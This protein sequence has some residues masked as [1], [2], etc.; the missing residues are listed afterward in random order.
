M[1]RWTLL[2]AALLLATVTASAKDMRIGVINSDQILANYT[3]YA[4]SMRILQEERADWDRQIANREAEIDAEMR[5]YKQ[6]EN[7]LSPVTRSERRAD[8]D[9]KLA[10]LEEFKGE[11][12]AEGTGRFFRRNQELMEPL[13]ERVNEA[14]RSVAEEEGYDLIL[15]NSMP[16]VVYVAENAIDVNL[17]QKV[18]DKLQ[19]GQ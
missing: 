12:Y 8:I 14:I 17:N 6:Q 4:S 3:E 5:S 18:L 10:E 1:K 7:A 11:V 9:R 16:V 19:G 15:D 13:I 2:L